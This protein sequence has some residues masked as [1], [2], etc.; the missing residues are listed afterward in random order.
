MAGL[1][2]LLL[3]VAVV[4]VWRGAWGVGALTGTV[5]AGNRGVPAVPVGSGTSEWA[6]A[7][8]IRRAIR[9]PS[10]GHRW[11][12]GGRLWHLSVSLQPSLAA[13]PL[14][15]CF[16]SCQSRS[17]DGGRRGER[18]RGRRLRGYAGTHPMA[19][20]WHRAP[21]T[22]PTHCAATGSVFAGCRCRA[23]RRRG[24]PAAVRPGFPR[25]GAV[26]P[27][28]PPPPQHRPR[29]RFSPQTFPMTTAASPSGW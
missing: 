19:Q 17:A 4:V 24:A 3:V 10:C 8:A 21:P 14:V 26:P 15:L 20:A 5:G 13:P 27:R 25:A 9:T 2:L 22:P 29:C 1:A 11:W 12:R 28:Q 6:S 18:S 16:L 23:G 7:K